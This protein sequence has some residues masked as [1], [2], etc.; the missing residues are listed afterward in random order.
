MC[1]GHYFEIVTIIHL[2]TEIQLVLNSIMHTFDVAGRVKFRAVPGLEGTRETT[3]TI[4]CK[5]FKV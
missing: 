1:E 5:L 4:L 3:Y 2:P